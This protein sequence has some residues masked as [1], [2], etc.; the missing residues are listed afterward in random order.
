MW[1]TEK[2]QLGREKKRKK[3]NRI[4]AF[5]RFTCTKTRLYIKETKAWKIYT[6]AN[7]L[8]S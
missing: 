6:F 8:K 7:F 3:K 2:K 4:A 5:T 1:D